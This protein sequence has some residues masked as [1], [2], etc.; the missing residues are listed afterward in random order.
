MTAGSSSRHT[1]ASFSPTWSALENGRRNADR[2]KFHLHQRFSEVESRILIIVPPALR[3]SWEAELDEF[4]LDGVA[5]AISNGSL[6]KVRDPEKYD[7]IIVDE[8]HKFR[9]DTAEGYDLLQKLCKMPTRVRLPDGTFAKKR[10]ILIS[11]TPLNNRPADIKNQVLLF[12]DGKDSHRARQS[13]ALLR[14]ANQ[15][16]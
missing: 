1:A 14:L 6:H 5:K 4:R 10:V 11:A 3:E 16:V 8:A 9:N 2:E 12:Q 13:P 7:L 15:G